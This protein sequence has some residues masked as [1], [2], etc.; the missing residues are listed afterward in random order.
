[1]KPPTK[2]AITKA[3][4]IL[5]ESIQ[6][7]NKRAFASR[8]VD[9][10]PLHEN[11]DEFLMSP[12]YQ[13]SCTYPLDSI[14]FKQLAT[15]AKALGLAK[16]YLNKEA[17][18]LISRIQHY[19]NLA[20]PIHRLP[21][22]ILVMILEIFA[23]GRTVHGMLQ[24]LRIGRLWYRAIVSAP[25]LWT[26]LD[27]ALPPKIARLVVER[28][29]NLP[30]LSFD[31][32][33]ANG[34]DHYQEKRKEILEIA[35]QNSTR[36]TLMKFQVSSGDPLEIRP[37]LEAPTPMLKN[38]TVEVGK[39]AVDRGV[40]FEGFVIS[41]G[42][43]LK[44]L[45]LH[46]ISLNFDSPRLSGLITLS[47][48]RS[49]VPTSL[50]NLLQVLSATQRL[51][52][53]TLGE[54]GQWIGESIALGPQV[55]LGH[56]KEL[57]VED[58]TNHY[59][60]TL[61]SSICTP[62]CSRVYV[63]DSRQSDGTDPLDPLIWQPGNTQTATLLGLGQQSDTRV[64]GISITA[65]YGV[66]IIHVR[67]Q[68]GSDGR[69]FS[70]TRPQPWELLK[71]LGQ[72]LND[73]PFGPPVDLT[74]SGGMALGNSFDL[75]PWGFLLKSLGLSNPT[76]CVRVLEQ[77]AQRTA[78]PSASERGTNATQVEDWVCPNL[79]YITLYNMDIESQR[80]SLLSLVRKRWSG[81]ESGVA[82]ANP[83]SGFEII[84]PR[85]VYKDLRELELEVQKVVPAFV[86][87]G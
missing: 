71:L 77:L 61:L 57:K 29:K 75:A 31:W 14:P 50:P 21:E 55:T 80:E 7:E 79:Q 51:E 33:T 68:G 5:L 27:S 73:I 85:S 58:I 62:I 64:L 18:D 53:L 34:Q 70:F 20:A 83:P 38:L 84:C 67:E 30:I 60:A 41:D 1:M 82:P 43:P 37:L 10:P 8:L 86:F 72:F 87:R 26:R 76:A 78:V 3:L 48:Y 2:D 22:E 9:T 46:D 35:L 59:C 19:R 45:V 42:V 25:Q 12:G 36:F 24:L 16:S 6:E 66:V 28:S 11:F 32:N 4:N 49:A 56:L 44:H 74:I 13:C 47:L 69:F 54:N 65:K 23:A 63:R 52:E 17:D 15:N 40:G 81:T 39:G